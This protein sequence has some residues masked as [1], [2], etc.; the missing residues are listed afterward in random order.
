VIGV[1]AI[2][3]ALVRVS[4]VARLR[5]AAATVPRLGGAVLV[6]TGAYVAY[7]GRYELRLAGNLRL[8]A[9]D[10]V[11]NAASAVQHA[12]SGLVGRVGAGWL[13]V[14]LV[15]LAAAGLAG[16]RPPHRDGH[17]PGGSPSG[18]AGAGAALSR[19]GVSSAATRRAGLRRQ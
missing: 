7:Y 6:V 5:R 2:A 17:R 3:V 11:V 15:L 10:P 18:R 16:A 8:S 14:V 4:A 12:V 13:A 19:P 1:T 9:S